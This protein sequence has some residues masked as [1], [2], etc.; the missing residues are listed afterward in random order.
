MTALLTAMGRLADVLEQENTALA[1]MDLRR[2][3]ASLPEKTAAFDALAA[4]PPTD[5]PAL[6][7]EA[8][9]LVRLAHENRVA[10][11][12]AI[13]AQQRVIKI[14][15]RAL[16]TVQAAPAYGASGRV[17]ARGGPMAWSARV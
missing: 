10:L 4:F 3:A 7:S 2:A 6:A 16:M 15:V 13:A 5:D 11:R 8:Q 14:V 17:V 1:V 12:R 9:R